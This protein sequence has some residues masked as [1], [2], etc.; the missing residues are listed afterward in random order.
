[1]PI[2]DDDT[3]CGRDTSENRS[4]IN[5]IIGEEHINLIIK[6]M[7]IKKKKRKNIEKV[8]VEAII[9][10]KMMIED[11]IE[12]NILMNIIILNIE[13]IKKILKKFIHR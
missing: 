7:K 2:T 3:V 5:I 4:T 9:I 11:I 12:E 1:M 6:Q 10:Q 8:E 13:K